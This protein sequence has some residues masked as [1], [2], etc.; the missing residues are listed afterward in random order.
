[1]PRRVK[2]IIDDNSV[3]VPDKII[4]QAVKENQEGEKNY[5]QDMFDVH[6][7]EGMVNTEPEMKIV[8]VIINRLGH[9]GA[10]NHF[11]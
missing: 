1:M 4:K 2:G 9:V 10:D 11:F 5:N 7:L 6:Y 8:F 3:V